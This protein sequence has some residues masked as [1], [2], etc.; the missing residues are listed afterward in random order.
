MLVI[1]PLGQTLGI[2][3][4]VSLKQERIKSV[5]VFKYLT[6]FLYLIIHYCS[7]AITLSVALTTDAPGVIST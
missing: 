2:N 4:Y 7:T 3:F 1:T 5:P 6:K